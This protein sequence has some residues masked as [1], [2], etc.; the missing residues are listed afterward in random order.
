MEWERER[1]GGCGGDYGGG[2]GGGWRNG[3]LSGRGWGRCR[4]GWVGVR[5]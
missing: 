4:V 2:G 1:E 3:T 5:C